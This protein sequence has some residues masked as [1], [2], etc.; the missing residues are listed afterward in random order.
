MSVALLLKASKCFRDSFF[1]FFSI[2]G[3]SF[4]GA[5]FRPLNDNMRARSRS[6][7]QPSEALK[8]TGFL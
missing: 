8:N 1:F 4:L 2:P 5:Q 3:M 7:Q 6:L